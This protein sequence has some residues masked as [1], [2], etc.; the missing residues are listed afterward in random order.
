MQFCP[1]EGALGGDVGETQES[2]HEGELPRMI[3]LQAGN[4]FAVGKEG[5]LTE[6]AELAAIDEGLQDVLLDI[7]VVVDDGGKLLS[8][9]G[10]MVDT[11][12]DAGSR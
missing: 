10:E 4:A 7:E 12:V 1:G 8:E 11:F 6:L 9:R 2:V 3:E 5:G